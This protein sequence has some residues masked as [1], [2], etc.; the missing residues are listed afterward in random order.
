MKKV[1]I[2]GFAISSLHLAPFNNKE[3]EIWGL[4]DLH[5]QIKADNIT[6]WFDIHPREQLETMSVRNGIGTYLD[7]LRALPCPVYMQEQHKDIPN[8]KSYPRAI[9][10]A[11]YGT[12]FTNSISWMLAMAIDEGYKEIHLYGVDM[13][14]GSEYMDQR[15]SCEYFIGLARGMG[16]IVKIPKESDLLKAPH[17]YGFEE[18]KQTETQKKYSDRWQELNKRLLH[19]EQEEVKALTNAGYYQLVKEKYFLLGALE[20]T[21]YYMKQW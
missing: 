10:T 18:Q 7:G 20:D 6:R 8:S 2:C 11:K 15:P 17:L 19:I 9:M 5:T 16:I 14:Q 1:A 4:N 21:E 13:A 12:Y 3:F